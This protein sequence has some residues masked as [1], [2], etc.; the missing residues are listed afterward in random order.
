MKET[1]PITAQSSKENAHNN[2]F[3]AFFS[4]R[5][6]VEPFL[7][8]FVEPQLDGQF[9]YDSLELHS[10]TYLTP[11]LMPYYSDRLWSVRYK[12]TGETVQLMLLF[13]HKSNVPQRV[14]IQLLRYMIEDWTKQI[15]NQLQAF[16]ESKKA[17]EKKRKKIRL[18]LILPIILYHGKREWKVPKFEDLFG[19]VS[20]SLKRF[21]PDFEPIVIDLYKY[22]DETLLKSN[23]GLLTNALLLFRHSFD[24]EYLLNNVELIMTGIENYPPDSD[25]ENTIKAL[26][27]YLLKLLKGNKM[28]KGAVM[29]KVQQVRSKRDFFSL[30]DYAMWEGEQKVLIRMWE[31][32]LP[33]EDIMKVSEL[34][35]NRIKEVLKT[36]IGK[37]N[38]KLINMNL[39]SKKTIEDIAKSANLSIKATQRIVDLLKYNPEK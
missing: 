14:H 3:Q 27:A 11:E 31:H 16:Q 36:H 6:I 15:D 7:Q 24:P 18:I 35:L 23:L 12:E 34:S 26:I 10:E 30:Y 4:K 25:Y 8:H 1:Q 9:D 32:D 5:F 20:A 2:A 37:D 38:V 21:L 33:L 13:E 19:K 29:Q 22:N 17:G 28:E 39:K